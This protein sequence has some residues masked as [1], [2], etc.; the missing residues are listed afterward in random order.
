[1]PRIA[2][3]LLAALALLAIPP[4]VVR[5]QVVRGTVTE[6]GTGLPIPGVLISLVDEHDQVI[7]TVFTDERA[8]FEIRAPS[9][10][11]Y[12]IDAKRIGVRQLRGA[13]FTIAVGENRSENIT[14]D[15]VI[16]VLDRVAV[17]GRSKC[18]QRPG[19]DAHTAALWEDARAA[20]TATILTARRPPVGTLTRFERSLD[21]GSRRVLHDERKEAHGN[22]SRPFVSI[23]VDQL[24]REGYAVRRSDGSTDFYAPDADALLSEAFLDDHCFRFVSGGD[25]LPGMVGLG[26]EPVRGR[27]VADI[28][29][30]LWLDEATSELSKLEFTY[31]KLPFEGLSERFGG[32][33]RFSRLPTG[34]WIVDGWVIRM[35]V[36]GVRPGARAILPGLQMEMKERPVLLAI[37]ESGGSVRLDRTSP[38][39]RVSIAG[40]VF[41]SS[42]GEA[43][44]GARVSIAGTSIE[45]TTAA[46]GRFEISKVPQ[47]L[48]IIV[49]ST[50]ALDSLGVA[51]P[52]DTVRVTARGR[53]DVALAT[54]SRPAIAQRMCPGRS[55]E[56]RGSALRILVLD[57]A[58]GAPLRGVAARV[59]WRNF[60]GAVSTRNLTEHVDGVVA[61]LDSLG[62][63]TVCDLPANTTIYVA[64]LPDSLPAWSATMQI[65]PG[66]IGW[67]VLKVE[68]S[69]SVEAQPAPVPS[70]ARDTT[71]L[72]H[73]PT[74]RPAHVRIM[75][76][77]IGSLVSQLA[78][79][80]VE[81]WHEEDRA[82]VDDDHQ[83]AAA[84]RSIDKLNQRRNDLVERID[85][86]VV[87]ALN[88][89]H[90]GGE[91][92]GRSRG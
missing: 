65:A 10:G 40:V 39:P 75:N 6:R 51:G 36:L 66:E 72:I 12:A 57:Q 33:V 26:F 5:A 13:P 22:V 35:P 68:R 29:G 2:P 52:A 24:S 64:S 89:R 42:T 92:E 78:R 17:T 67:R 91:G 11:R 82:R 9:A 34:R 1:M 7:T 88:E 27:R 8:E 62:S 48:Y 49:A 47:G 71:L 30:V 23:P 32:E 44:S 87:R 60:T 38:P 54:P 74:P 85:A 70:A 55:R 84:K 20:L 58:T 31:V 90:A 53:A 3:T 45:A 81:L 77:T 25:S 50:P 73:H 79:T 16:S 56:A 80:N 76:D 37:Q 86:E 61:R 59:W 18:T 19:E 46:D 83:V 63:Y 21:P 4:E 15:P 43:A 14:L 28:T 41:D 69:A